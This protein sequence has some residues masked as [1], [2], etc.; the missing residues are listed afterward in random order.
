MC[1]FEFFFCLQKKK[2]DEKLMIPRFEGSNC[3]DDPCEIC[4]HNE[5]QKSKCKYHKE[6]EEEYNKRKY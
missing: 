5:C 1:L 3:I 6:M 4:K 2:G